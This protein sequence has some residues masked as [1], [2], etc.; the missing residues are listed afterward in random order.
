MLKSIYSLKDLI[1]PVICMICNTPGESICTNCRIPWLR[2]PKKSKIEKVDLY[3][4]ANYTPESSQLILAAKERGNKDAIDLLASAISNS[5]Q[6]AIYEL[7]I[8]SP[9]N[10]VTIPSKNLA[11]RRRGRDHISELALIVIN[12]LKKVSIESSYQPLLSITRKVKDQSGLNSQQRSENIK[13]AYIVKNSLI[14]Q[15]EVILIDDLITTG[16]SIQE[17]IRA[18]KAAEIAVSAVTTACAVGRNSLIR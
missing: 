15:G 3:F 17:G 4:A 8:T 7:K 9:I 1:Y 11:I 13:G 16:S 14:P 2:Q 10:L 5:I 6:I 18:L 12:Q